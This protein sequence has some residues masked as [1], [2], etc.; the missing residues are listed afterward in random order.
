MKCKKQCPQFWIF[1]SIFGAEL[2]FPSLMKV[3]VRRLAF[4]R[5]LNDLIPI[6]ERRVM[7][8]IRTLRGAEKYERKLLILFYFL[9]FYF[10]MWGPQTKVIKK[11]EKKIRKWQLEMFDFS[12]MEKKKMKNKKRKKE[13]NRNFLAAVGSIYTHAADEICGDRYTR[14]M[15]QTEST[16]RTSE[17]NSRKILEKNTKILYCNLGIFKL[18]FGEDCSSKDERFCL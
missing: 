9:S 13:K 14:S 16:R 12:K 15:T 10:S 5:I 4:R 3:V 18:V 8:E 1:S 6:P 2:D 7:A 17:K 11:K